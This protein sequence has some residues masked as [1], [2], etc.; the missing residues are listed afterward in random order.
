LR[1]S[2]KQKRENCLIS[3]SNHLLRLFKIK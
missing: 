2:K 3:S 1:K